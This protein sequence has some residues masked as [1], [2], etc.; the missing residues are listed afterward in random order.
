MSEAAKHELIPKHQKIND[1]EKEQLLEKYGIDVNDLPKIFI[2]D[3]AIADLG[4]KSGDVVKIIRES[5]TAGTTTYY[6]VVING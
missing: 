5:K 2:K 3:P 4:V 1:S 6:R